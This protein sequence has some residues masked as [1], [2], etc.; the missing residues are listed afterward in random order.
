MYLTCANNECNGELKYL[1][2]GRLFLMEREPNASQAS[3][4]ANCDVDADTEMPKRRVSALRYFWL[5]EKCAERYVIQHWTENGIELA[6]KQPKKP[7]Q[8]Y[9]SPNTSGWFLPG[10]VG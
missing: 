2:G 4:R 9:S 1:R 3:L 8:S 6:P 10:L 7:A 5:C